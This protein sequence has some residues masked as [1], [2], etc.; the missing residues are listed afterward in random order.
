MLWLIAISF[1]ILSALLAYLIQ[2]RRSIRAL[3]WP[4]DA[5]YQQFIALVT[6]YLK[7]QGWRVETGRMTHILNASRNEQRVRILCQSRLDEYNDAVVRDICQ[8]AMELALA[9]GAKPFVC[10][11]ARAV[12]AQFLRVLA[13]SGVVFVHYKQLGMLREGQGDIAALLEA[14]RKSQLEGSSE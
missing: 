1:L 10:V 12:P 2:Q 11:A 6:G 4:A 7:S 8:V 14:M 5:S 3:R 13:A 9:P